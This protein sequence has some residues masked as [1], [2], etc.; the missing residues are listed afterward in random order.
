MEH[1]DGRES[2]REAADNQ[3]FMASEIYR[4]GV[5]YGLSDERAWQLGRDCALCFLGITL[6]QG[7]SRDSRDFDVDAFLRNLFG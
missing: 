5:E 1:S 4:R 3:A 7:G 6:M 2:M